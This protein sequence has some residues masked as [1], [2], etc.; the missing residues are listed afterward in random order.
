MSTEN[1]DD[2]VNQ[3]DQAEPSSQS[4]TDG[5]KK[6]EI[7]NKRLVKKLLWLVIGAIAFAFALVPFYNLMCA[8]TGLNGKTDNTAS[9]LAKAKV[10]DTRVVTVEF[11]ASV[12]SGLGWNFAPKQARI[13][14]H[15]GQIATVL[16]E[17]K[18]TTTQVLAGQAIPSVTPGE[19][20]IYLKKIECFCFQRQ[21]LKPGEVKEMPLRFFIDPALPKE[22]KVMTLSYS[23][24]PAVEV[25]K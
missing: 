11:V 7:A 8:V 20:A 21:T 22:V 10:D 18:N 6:L 17:A 2:V 14:L 12:M 1:K 19:G 15:P 24:F 3:N 13:T 9:T 4:A 5:R 23:F 25:K 16:F